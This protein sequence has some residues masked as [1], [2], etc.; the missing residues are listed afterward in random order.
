MYKHHAE[1]YSGPC[2]ISTMEPLCE[3]SKR[4]KAVNYFC[5]KALLNIFD[6][7]LKNSVLS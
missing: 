4:F 1:A 7:V 5:K 2:H 3:N 6:R